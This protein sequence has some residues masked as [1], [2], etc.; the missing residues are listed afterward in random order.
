MQLEQCIR[1]IPGFPKD[2]I[3]FRD[4]TTLM[5]NKEAFKYVND[6][7]YEEYK[8]KNITAIAGVEARGFIFGGVLADRLGV[9]FIPVRKKG[10]LPWEVYTEKYQLEYGEDFLEIHKD[11][12]NDSDN[13]V[14]IDDLLATG[15]TVEATTKLLA[16]FNTNI[17]G[18]AFVI[19]LDDLKGRDKLTEYSIFSLVHFEGE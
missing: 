9:K 19:E 8:D 13:V 5:G 14:I 1:N 2:G 18:I 11:A 4:I 6:K 17:K 12:I 15:G 10:K 3:I 7:F 16:N